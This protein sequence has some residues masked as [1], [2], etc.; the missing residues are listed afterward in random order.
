MTTAKLS[1]L[2][3]SILELA[4]VNRVAEG[5]H[6]ESSGAD[7]YFYELMVAC[8]GF[9]TPPRRYGETDRRRVPGSQRFSRRQIGAARYDAAQASV[10]RAVRR[11]EDRGLVVRLCGAVSHW[12]GL[13]LSPAGLAV[14]VGLA[15]NCAET[16]PLPGDPRTTSVAVG[17]D[18]DPRTTQPAEESDRFADESV[19]SWVNCPET[20]PLLP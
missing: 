3:R 12:S 7:L 15:H 4:Y 18:A 1:R 19:R 8:F 6:S 13:S 10:S 16:Q 20:Q 14:A 5:R 11:L 2:Q 9:P 17:S